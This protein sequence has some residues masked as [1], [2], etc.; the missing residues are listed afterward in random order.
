MLVPATLAR[1]RHGAVVAPHHLATEAG[2]SIL[3]AGGSAVDAA[4]ATNAV[5]AV[6]VPS[7][8]GIGGDAF[9][10]VWEAATGREY[11]LNGSGRAPASADAAALRD[12]GMDAL[13][14]RGPLTITVPGAVRSW[15]DAHKRFGRL[16]RADI[17]APAIELARNGFPAWAGLIGSI[18]RM[19][20]MVER[21][22]GSSSGFE[23]VFRP[24]GRPWREGELIRLPALATTLESL[25]TAGFEDFYEGDVGQ[26]QA[27]G[28]AAAGCGITWSDLRAHTLDVGR[29][30]RDRVP[31]RRALRPIRRTRRGSW[32]S[33]CSTSSSSSSHRRRRRG[34]RRA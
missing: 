25:A 3:R 4:I 16:S 14:L 23:R 27:R 15:G 12:Q 11:A 6:V 13:P 21:A 32:R 29:S 22:I 5:L 31:R 28:L 24:H 7:N 8:C 20:V 19:F 9:W 18:E 33:S 26:R 2:L 30:D 1:G 17:L 34:A 10:L